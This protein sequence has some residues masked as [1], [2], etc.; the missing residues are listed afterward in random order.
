[1]PCHASRNDRDLLLSI[2]WLL[3]G[4]MWLSCCPDSNVHNC[5]NK[6]WTHGVVYNK[7]SEWSGRLRATIECCMFS[8][9]I[10]SFG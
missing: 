10:K 3:M 5:M 7:K 1:M 2:M 8:T 4:I 6:D 9:T